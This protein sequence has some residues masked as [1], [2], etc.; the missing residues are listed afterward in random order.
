MA[1]QWAEKLLSQRKGD[2]VT[3]VNIPTQYTEFSD[4]FS[5]SAVR[6]FPPAREDD[7]AIEFKLNVPNT[8]S[9]KIYPISHRETEFLRGW[10]NKNLGKR[11]IRGSK[12]PYASPTFLIKK[13]NGDFSVIQDYRTLNEHTIPDVS[14]LPLIGSIIDKLHGQTLFTKFDIRWGYHNIQNTRQRPGKS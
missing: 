7:H 11:F 10:I 8:F 1:Q 4:V 12:S 13:K 5:E 14:P 3:E 9:C 6:R 2:L